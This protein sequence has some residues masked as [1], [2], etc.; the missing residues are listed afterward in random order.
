MAGTKYCPAPAPGHVVFFQFSIY[1]RAGPWESSGKAECC[2]WS[3]ATLH[4]GHQMTVINYNNDAMLRGGR[5]GVPA[6]KRSLTHSGDHNNF[7]VC[8]LYD[9]VRTHC[10]NSMNSLAHP[11]GRPRFRCARHSARR[12]GGRFASA[13]SRRCC[14]SRDAKP[15][16]HGR[17]PK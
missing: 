16:K 6:F 4:S 8:K 11:F 13:G 17:R 9:C 10:D 7:T 14:C 5:A 1:D 15:K 12:G 2:P 3:G